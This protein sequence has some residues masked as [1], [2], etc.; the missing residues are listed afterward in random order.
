MHLA[1]VVRWWCS[2]SITCYRTKLQYFAVFLINLNFKEWPKF[3][4]LFDTITATRKE[5][6]SILIKESLNKLHLSKI[7]MI[8]LNKCPISHDD[9]DD[10]K[11]WAYSFSMLQVDPNNHKYTRIVH[12]N[13][14]RRP[15]E[16]VASN[17]LENY[18]DK[19]VKTVGFGRSRFP[20]WMPTY[21]K[22][23]KNSSPPFTQPKTSASFSKNEFIPCG[24]L[25]TVVVVC[26]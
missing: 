8:L 13:N 2:Y 19:Y 15:K 3:H 14:V 22:H 18:D 7:S 5:W 1:F 25:T 11:W 4:N 17:E 20:Y 16:C 10:Y 26:W 21:L 6:T 24:Q 9:D 12:T 23:S